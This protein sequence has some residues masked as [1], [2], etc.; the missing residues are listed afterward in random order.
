MSAAQMA[1]GSKGSQNLGS[2]QTPEQQMEQHNQYQAQQ[3][4][5]MQAGMQAWAQRQAGAGGLPQ[6]TTRS[7]R[8]FGLSATA[9]GGGFGASSSGGLFGSANN[10]T[11]LFSGPLFGPYA[12]ASSSG[13]LFGSANS[14]AVAQQPTSEGPFDLDNSEIDVLSTLS[15]LQTFSGNWKW[16]SSLEAILGIDTL[17]VTHK[18]QLPGWY[19]QHLD[20]LATLCAVVFLKKKL[21]SEKD[22]W[23]LLVQKAEDW[24]RAQTGADVLELEKVVE[25]K[26]WPN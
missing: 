16:N 11:P 19:N 7:G 17:S 8:P 12:S 9:P 24:L 4:A 26:L 6:S 20:V 3:M 1:Y 23:E 15:A 2:R 21:A 14:S 10:T 13:G 18:I 25:E 22:S 5:L